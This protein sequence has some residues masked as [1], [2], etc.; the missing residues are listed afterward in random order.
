MCL[1]DEESDDDD[2]E[3]CK[4]EIEIF[5]TS[6]SKHDLS[7]GYRAKNKDEKEKLLNVCQSF[8]N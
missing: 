2:D 5:P 8:I 4:L 3:G 7:H 6:M 1:E